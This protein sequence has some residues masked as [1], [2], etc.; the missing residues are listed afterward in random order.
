MTDQLGRER[1]RDDEIVQ[2]LRAIRSLLA[3]LIGLL[4]GAWFMAQ[5][6]YL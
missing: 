3:V 5:V 1:S 4:I 6:I 2:H